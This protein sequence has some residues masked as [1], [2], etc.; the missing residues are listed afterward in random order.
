MDATSSRTATS[1]CLVL[2]LLLFVCTSS[3]G[4]EWK[5]ELKALRE[6]ARKLK[7]AEFAEKT[8]P[9]LKTYA[10]NAEALT[11][12]QLLRTDSAWQRGGTH[13]EK[14][15]ELAKTLPMLPDDDV[16]TVT[17]VGERL[18][19]AAAVVGT[20]ALEASYA[21]VVDRFGDKK[22][23]TY[24]VLRAH[25]HAANG[26]LSQNLLEKALPAASRMVTLCN[27]EDRH[28]VSTCMQLLDRF[29]RERGRRK[30]PA[31]DLLALATPF[32][33][34]FEKKSFKSYIGRILPH[35]IALHIEQED[36][37]SGLAVS[38]QLVSLEPK[39]LHY[40]FHRIDALKALGRLDEAEAVCREVVLADPVG[41]TAFT[42]RARLVEIS[43]AQGDLQ[44][45][46]GRARLCFDTARDERQVSQAVEF[47]AQCMAARDSHLANANKYVLY[48]KS[49]VAGL[50]GKV[51]TADDLPA[52]RDVIP[53]S[54]DNGFKSV[55]EEAAAEECDPLDFGAL[56]R[57]SM[58][59]L[60][61]GNVEAS[62]ECF[63]TNFLL[64]QGDTK[65][66]E[67][68]ANDLALVLR[69]RHG[70]TFASQ[71]FVDFQT[72]GPH[73]RDGQPGTADDLQLPLK[74]KS[75]LSAEVVAEAAS[76]FHA[77]LL[78]SWTAKETIQAGLRYAS[79]LSLSGNRQ[80][81]LSLAYTLF[82]AAAD[83]GC[84]NLAAAGVAGALRARDL[85]LLN[86]NRF[87]AFQKHGAK[88]ADEKAQTEDDL[89][90]PMAG[91]A[92]TLPERH[93]TWL[94]DKA[95]TLS[96]A[97]DYRAASYAYLY[98]G[99]PEAALKNLKQARK[100]CAF[101][102]Q[103]IQTLTKD[104]IAAL[105]GLQGNTF[106]ATQF[107]AFQ[108][109]GPSGKDGKAG[110]DDDLKDPLEAF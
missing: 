28:H 85:H 42:A 59:Y 64:I 21:Q 76:A 20:D 55:L 1:P 94:Q 77:A 34:H 2:V 47:I 44:T 12:I 56:R 60:H 109:Y 82:A 54:I 105:K 104:I 49:G 16:K 29:M 18:I 10:G 46:L 91:Y 32:L 24:L 96:K 23:F 48:Q 100:T 25:S 79:A 11:Q 15:F 110:T 8:A 106:G 84:L 13:P 88:G 68:S 101:K 81:A 69:A 33:P 58:L 87:L 9:L 36:H 35:A 57:R 39:R 51:G 30:I 7:Y 108:Q 107:L 93:R 19:Q 43:L 67:Q 70:Y 40:Q 27:P 90:D 74:L 99:Q 73:G 86:A 5:D 92:V 41:Q 3:Q 98:L 37:E 80:A 26:Y 103:A 66:L 61:A 4:A 97:G 45:A 62:Q 78:R 31:A 72:F 95:A 17:R 22:A 83:N 6:S 65:A 50:D 38:E 75:A 53:R 102:R 71:P 89:A 52:Y 63:V 14:L